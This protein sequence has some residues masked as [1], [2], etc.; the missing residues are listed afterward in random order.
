MN[1]C[2]INEDIKQKQN[3]KKIDQTHTN[4]ISLSTTTKKV[5]THN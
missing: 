3:K 4:F 2:L 5:K 1:E